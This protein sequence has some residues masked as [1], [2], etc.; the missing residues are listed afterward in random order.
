MS[1][2]NNE[3]DKTDIDIGN[4]GNI[5]N[6]FRG[7]IGST[8]K[9][10]KINSDNI[11]NNYS[12][13]YLVEIAENY[14]QQ[15]IQLLKVKDY[16]GAIET[17]RNALN[18]TRTAS[19]DS[20]ENKKSESRLVRLERSKYAYYLALALLKGRDPRKASRE[21]IRKVEEQLRASV[22]VKEADRKHLARCFLLWAIVKHGYYEMNCLADEAPL[23]KDTSTGIPLFFNEFPLVEKQDAQE[24]IN[25]IYAPSNFFWEKLNIYSNGKVVRR[26]RKL[27]ASKISS[28]AL[29]ERR[30][31]VKKFFTRTPDKPNYFPCHVNIC[32]GIF[33]L[34]LSLTFLMSLDETRYSNGLIRYEVLRVVI[35]TTLLLPSLILLSK[36]LIHFNKLK[37]KY[38]KE[39]ADAE[40]KPTTQQIDDWL[41]SDIERIVN[42]DALECLN[43]YKEDCRTEPLV[44]VGPEFLEDGKFHISSEIRRRYPRTL[45]V[46]SKDGKD[47]YSHF[48]TLV[49]YLMKHH[50]TIYESVN[51]MESG[52]ALSYRTVEFPYQK[53]T[54]LSTEIINKIITFP[55]TSMVD[56]KI[57]RKK[58]RS[59]KVNNQQD[60]VQFVSERGLKKFSI[61]TIGSDEIKILY[62]FSKN[63]EL[64]EDD[65]QRV[66]KVRD[67]GERAILAVRKYLEDYEG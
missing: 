57:N 2:S 46:K 53:I 5:G 4:I 54:N 8:L 40:P 32:A 26:K 44:I 25:H 63:T 13:S 24:I 59:K 3:F 47:R 18:A 65:H 61:S 41:E 60:Q 55:S 34:F 50:I 9:N 42:E 27:S 7:V 33:L 62:P 30:I 36:G 17:L 58:F 66:C 19:E 38:V 23:P 64:L 20:D 16:T 28:K 29:E 1:K 31:A 11:T 14:F 52:Q 45:F 21:T 37:T 56:Q 22:S 35:L 12:Y 48:K 43:L 51:E 39:Y 67:P 10:S 15:G 6:D 49:I